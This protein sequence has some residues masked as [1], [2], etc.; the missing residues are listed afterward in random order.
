MLKWVTTLLIFRTKSIR[1]KTLA[2]RMTAIDGK[3]VV[4]DV[5]SGSMIYEP[6]MEDGVFRFDCSSDDRTSA[7]PSISFV[8]PNVRETPLMIQKGPSFTPT[9]E[10]T[11]GQQIVQ[12]EL[13]VGTTFYGT[14]EV[15][16]QFERTGKRV[17][18]WNTSAWGY[19]PSTTSLYQSHP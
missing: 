9:Y 14:G 4:S 8:N 18:T 6:I 3:G 13:P 16:G 10:R 19:G 11:L 12:L 15:G 5:S 2:C 1:S 7:F 17:F